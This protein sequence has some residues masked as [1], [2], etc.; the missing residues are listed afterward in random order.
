MRKDSKIKDK[1]QTKKQGKEIK[2]MEET[3]GKI[4]L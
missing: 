2:L 1:E 4:K 3:E